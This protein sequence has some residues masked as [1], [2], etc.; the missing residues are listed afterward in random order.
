MTLCLA[1]MAYLEARGEGPDGMLMVMDVAATRAEETR[2]DLCQVVA[3][4]NQFAFDPAFRSDTPQWQEAL[5]LAHRVAVLDDRPRTG[6]TN[7]HSG[8]PPGWTKHAQFI[9]KW[10]NHMFWRIEQ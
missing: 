7:F 1:I 8:P 6:A 9:G 3:E 2:K 4:P 5:A 10:G